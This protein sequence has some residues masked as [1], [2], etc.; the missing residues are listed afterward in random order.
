[1]KLNNLCD[2]TAATSYDTYLFVFFKQ[3]ISLVSNL[4]TS[5]LQLDQ[6]DEGWL[7]RVLSENSSLEKRIRLS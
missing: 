7:Y 2:I 4:L 5:R 6:W 3:F 1:M